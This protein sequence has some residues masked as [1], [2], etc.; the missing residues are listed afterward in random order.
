MQLRFPRPKILLWVLTTLCF[1]I[2]PKEG[3]ATDFPSEKELA[4]GITVTNLGFFCGHGPGYGRISLQNTK[5]VAYSLSIGM[6]V[7]EPSSLKRTTSERAFL[8]QQEVTVPAHSQNTFTIP[9]DCMRK[10]D[11]FLHFFTKDNQDLWSTSIGNEPYPVRFQIVL[12]GSSEQANV[13]QQELS[14][15]KS[16]SPFSVRVIPVSPE[17]LPD[18]WEYLVG[19]DAIV[20]NHTLS[21]EQTNVLHKYAKAGGKL[22][23]VALPMAMP[24][25]LGYI[26][27]TGTAK[28]FLVGVITADQSYDDKQDI[29]P[30]S[31]SSPKLRY[32]LQEMPAGLIL[33]SVL[34]FVVLAGPVNYLHWHRRRKK[35]MM[36][37]V[38]ISTLGILFT[39]GIFLYSAFV[40]G[41]GV[42]GAVVSWTYEDQVTND[43]V[44]VES[45]TLYAGK[46]PK[47][48]LFDKNTYFSFLNPD[49]KLATTYGDSISVS[50]D[51][52]PP[53]IHRNLLR[54]TQ[55]P[56][57][58][59]MVFRKNKDGSL[60]WISSTSPKPNRLIVRDFNG[61][62][63]VSTQQG[64]LEAI[65]S[66]MFVL[67]DIKR[68]DANLL[69]PEEFRSWLQDMP[70]GSYI[71]QTHTTHPETKRSFGLDV[72][73]KQQMH[74]VFGALAYGDFHE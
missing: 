39:V 28:D 12:V 1:F 61:N 22:F 15:D 17:D 36:T 33:M 68:T 66:P 60:E 41:L 59:R 37:L 21:P 46:S 35:P 6:R 71:F 63:Y 30:K 64:S 48:F 8:F 27:T 62:C 10:P 52:L 19:F 7:T 55:K 18:G 58:N 44:A 34:I 9:H 4:P 26:Q 16:S 3:F 43:S 40:E 23:G 53:R 31:W 73:Y 51:A 45:Y 54:V 29:F 69:I 74:L 67:D 72:A 50:G 49:T 47:E 2:L 57:Q 5:D 70:K 32:R 24:M 13:L 20:V 14:N 42:R 56:I 38:G 65:G 11:H 25:G